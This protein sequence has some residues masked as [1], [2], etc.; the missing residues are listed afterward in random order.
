MVVVGYR[1][2]AIPRYSTEC[3]RNV[4]SMMVRAHYITLWNLF[5]GLE[6]MKHGRRKSRGHFYF[7]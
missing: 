1:V 4:V 2:R 5:G 6:S 7:F 3:R